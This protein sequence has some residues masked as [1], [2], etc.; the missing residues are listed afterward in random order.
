LKRVSIHVNCK[1]QSLTPVK[2]IL[3]A[4]FVAL[5][6]S[7]SNNHYFQQEVETVQHRLQG[8]PNV[9][10][11]PVE[12]ERDGNSLRKSWEF[13]SERPPAGF[14]DW[15]A[16]QLGHDYHVTSRTASTADFAK[17]SQGDDV[18][19]TLRVNPAASGS[20]VKCVLQAMPD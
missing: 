16:S 8:E 17:E 12:P 15:A 1:G 14:L 6:P 7:C 2:S 13:Q 9:V 20:L 3:L 10:A 4:I 5:S 18:Y 19:L 11:R